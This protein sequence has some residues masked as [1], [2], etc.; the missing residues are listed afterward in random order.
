MQE[1]RFQYILKE[2]D[3]K[4]QV[5]VALLAGRLKVSEVTVRSD[6]AVLASRGM[7]ERVH[8]GAVK[9]ADYQYKSRTKD[10]VYRNTSRKIAIAREAMK[11]VEPGMTLLIDDSS[12]CLYLVRLLRDTPAAHCV[13]ITNS[14]YAVMELLEADHVNVRLLGGEVSKNLGATYNFDDHGRELHADI[15]FIGANGVSVDKGATVIDY[16]QREAKQ[17]LLSGAD[18]KVLLADSSKFDRSYASVVAPIQ[19][20]DLII[21]DCGLPCELAETYGLSADLILA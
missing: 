9:K 6:L 5:Q 13:V 15:C 8:G 21:T 7:L 14:V 2:L 12:T 1:E 4:G 11:M 18:R 16:P 20:F 10:T 17:F 19:A 3:R